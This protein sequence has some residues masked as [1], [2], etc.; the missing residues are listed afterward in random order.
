MS[1]E[2]VSWLEN[3]TSLGA[4]VWC[5]Q[6]CITV[7]SITVTAAHNIQLNM[8]CNEITVFNINIY[9]ALPLCCFANGSQQPREAALPAADS[10][11][12][13]AKVPVKAV[14]PQQ[15]GIHCTLFLFFK[16]CPALF[17]P[18]LFLSSLPESLCVLLFFSNLLCVFT[19]FVNSVPLNLSLLLSGP[20]G[21]LQSISALLSICS[22]GL[23]LSRGRMGLYFHSS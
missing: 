14:S 10:R 11:T 22:L 23:G 4:V 21:T 12:N 13:C 1:S 2:R 8:T 6:S 18:L 15:H 3:F 17:P 9:V 19:S 16:R 20:I 5:S 7:Q